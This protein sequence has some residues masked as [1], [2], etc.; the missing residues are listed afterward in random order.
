L[1]ILSEWVSPSISDSNSYQIKI[2]F[3]QLSSNSWNIVSSITFSSDKDF[4]VSKFR[5]FFNKSL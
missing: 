5:E 1:R 4:S 3:S 2:I